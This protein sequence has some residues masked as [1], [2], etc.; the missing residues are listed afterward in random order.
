MRLFLVAVAVPAVPCCGG[1]ASAPMPLPP[2]PPGCHSLREWA[3]AMDPVGAPRMIFEET[4]APDEEMCGRRQLR[5]E[6][7]N[8]GH[9]EWWDGEPEN[10]RLFLPR[11]TP[12][13]A[14]PGIR[15]CAS[16]EADLA[17]W[18]LPAADAT[19]PI[20]NE[21]GGPIAAEV[22]MRGEGFAILTPWGASCS[23]VVRP[24]ADAGVDVV[25]EC[26]F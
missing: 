1:V 4:C 6:L 8:G 26:S 10:P 19:V 13:S 23:L 14:W 16:L 2:A 12:A 25:Q 15:A 24:T 22:V 20:P 11:T 9:V 7:A 21:G 18:P 5:L 3:E 17:E